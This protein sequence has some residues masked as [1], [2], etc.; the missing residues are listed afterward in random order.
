M[1]ELLSKLLDGPLKRFAVFLVS[2]GIVALNKKL[3][4]NLSEVEIAS[5]ASMTAAYLV[6]SGMK[7]AAQM[8]AEAVKQAAE[9]IKTP[10]AVVD[11]LKQMGAP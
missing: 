6:Q 8:K 4:L 9:D 7:A 11:Q 10:A 3:G 2:A 1:S 5:L